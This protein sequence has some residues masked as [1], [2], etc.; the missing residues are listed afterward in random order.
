MLFSQ[1][2]FTNE[3]G[4]GLG[5]TLEFYALVSA[6]L[7]K[8]SLAMWIT[9][10]SDPTT[11]TERIVDIGHGIKEP[12][13][14]VQRESGLFPAPYPPSQAVQVAEYFRFLGCLL[15]KALQDGRLVDIPLSQPFLKLMCMGEVGSNLARHY[16]IDRCSSMGA[17]AGLSDDEGMSDREETT[18]A[19]VRGLNKRAS[20]KKEFYSVTILM[21]TS[22][23][24]KF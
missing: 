1:I 2:E 14:Y 12:G 5:P 22:S 23:N 10:D 16:V 6:E 11:S 13:F 24:C 7:Q 15:A 18:P 4:T 21:L 20:C 3:E 8:K 9:D 19:E 17:A